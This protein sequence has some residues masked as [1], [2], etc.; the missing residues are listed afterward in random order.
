MDRNAKIVRNILILAANVRR[1]DYK[2]PAFPR[3]PVPGETA[4]DDVPAQ[5]RGAA[6]DV[7]VQ[8]K[9]DSDA[10]RMLVH[11]G[12]HRILEALLRENA[13]VSQNKLAELVDIRKQ[14]LSEVV[15]RMERDGLVERRLDAKDQRKNLIFLSEEGRAQALAE[16]EMRSDEANAI[17]APLTEEE[18]NTLFVLL[19]KIMK[20]EDAE[21]II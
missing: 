14:S 6:K 18:Q 19:E 3:P 15:V 2:D 17:L 11:S 13:G 1:G 4:P 16:V 21:R 12:S 7:K 20:R 8:G 5:H 10:M 9:S